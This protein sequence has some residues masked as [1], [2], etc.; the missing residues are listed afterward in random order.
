MKAFREYSKALHADF[1]DDYAQ[2]LEAGELKGQKA[3]TDFVARFRPSLWVNLARS[4]CLGRQTTKSPRAFLHRGLM[5]DL[6]AGAGFEP[7]AFRL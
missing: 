6:V 5:Y 3:K 1:V 7:A 4:C 2:R